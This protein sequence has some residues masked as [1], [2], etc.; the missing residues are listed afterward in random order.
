MA[1]G[2]LSAAPRWTCEV[3]LKLI[4]NNKTII[5]ALKP[6]YFT[7]QYIIFENIQE[8]EKLLLRACSTSF[9][10]IQWEKDNLLPMSNI[11]FSHCVFY[12]FGELSTISSQEKKMSSANSF[13]LEESKICCMGKG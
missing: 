6:T 4:K 5:Y 8:K 10:K 12:H 1:H 9:L 13:N 2:F 7:F 11:S 3:S